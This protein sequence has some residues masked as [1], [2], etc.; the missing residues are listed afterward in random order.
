M[1]PAPKAALKG[2]LSRSLAA[3]AACLLLASCTAD[4]PSPGSGTGASDVSPGPVDVPAQASRLPPLN[5]AGLG[6]SRAVDLAKL[7][8][9]MVVNLFAQWCAPCRKELP[10]FEQ[11]HQAG[12]GTVGVLGVDYLDTQPGRALEL[13]RTAGVTYPLVADPA[14][15]LRTDLRIRG[16]PGV[17]LLDADGKVADV[18]FRAFDSYAELQTFVEQ[19]LGV[20][21]PS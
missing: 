2:S 18:E 16:L 19:G 11:L 5:L 15:A 10:Y 3:L 8:G 9:P 14:G 6:G 1:R 21:I 20:S 17:V 4:Q 12:K 7:R 13:V